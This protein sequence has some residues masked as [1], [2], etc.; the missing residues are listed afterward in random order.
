MTDKLLREL[1][2]SEELATSLTEEKFAETKAA[3]VDKI[4]TEL[5]EQEDFYASL[6]VS[7]LPKEFSK[8]HFDEG[9]RKVNDLSRQAV[10]KHL[11][12]SEED[13]KAWNQDEVRDIH[14]YIAKAVGVYKS[15]AGVGSDDVS[16]LQD[17]NMNLKSVLAE[18]EESIKSLNDKF[19]SELS[20]RL[21]AKET[22][23]LAM[24]EASRLQ[25]AIPVPV[26]LIFDK[27]FS[28]IKSKYSVT[29]ENGVAGVRKKDNPSFRV[30][31]ADNKGY[32]TLTDVLQDEL[33]AMGVWKEEEKKTEAVKI[34]VEPGKGGKISEKIK[35]AIERENALFN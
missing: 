5:L 11:G 35:E 9:V 27:V 28:G 26:G 8:S 29:V 7:K 30:P 18:R 13:K 31:T 6:D 12:I 17:E 21:T 4:K 20:A 24:L 10:D 33:K 1:G 22:E 14:K 23:T 19:E 25:S 3:I 2:V 32:L 34:S 15:K 16:K